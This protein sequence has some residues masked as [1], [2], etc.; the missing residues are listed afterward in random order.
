[1]RLRRVLCALT[2]AF[3]ACVLVLPIAASAADAPGLSV[4]DID[5]SAFPKVTFRVSVPPALGGDG[6][7]PSFTLSENGSKVRGATAE[8]LTGEATPA[9]VVLVID[10]SGSM[11]GKPL[12]DA[13]AAATRFLETLG[14]NASVAIVTFADKPVVVQPLTSDRG[15][16]TGSLG[17]LAAHGETALW[18]ALVTA[19]A[20]VPADAAGQRGIVVLSDGG[21]TVSSASF[22]LAVSRVRAAGAPVYAVALTSGEANPAALGRL[23]MSSGGRLVPVAK[24]GELSAS[25]E[26]IAREIRN[27]YLVTYTSKQPR[28]K[29]VEVDLEA[30]VGDRTASAAFAFSNPA[31]A[32][33]GLAATSDVFVPGVGT[34]AQRLL[35]AVLLGFGAVALLVGGVLSFVIRDRTT[36]DQ[37]RY[38]DQLH[39]AGSVDAGSTADQVRRSVVDAVGEVAGRRGLTPLVMAKLESAGMPLRPAEYMTL[40][41][42]LVVVAG[43]AAELVTG[44][45]IVGLLATIGMT[46]LPIVLLE[47]AIGRRRRKFEEQLPDILSMIAG[48]LRG[49]WGVQQAIGLV[50]QEAPAPSATEFRRVDTETRLGI[51]LEA[52]LQS[53]ASRMGSGDFQAAV[54]AI[55]I[56]REVGGN[57][58]EVLDVVSKTIRE[59]ES[60]RRHIK[61]LTA[62]GRLSAYILTALPFVVLGAMSV[63]NPGYIDLLFTNV[64]GIA[65]TLIGGVLLVVGIFWMYRVTKIEV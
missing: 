16:L 12:D 32:H 41:I 14:G 5:T 47:N 30:K 31:L 55:A 49:G 39:G 53:M 21:D 64:L 34:D 7:R 11:K 1:M 50:V 40:H 42:L 8:P 23:A 13:R 37:L 19:A 27:A 10:T 44:R 59:R 61:S 51:P 36:L 63:I 22:D 54:T 35:Y 4:Q 20:L 33:S 28:S 29:D 2:L 56:Q 62:E 15:A 18:D 43:V 24:S 9:R 52:S 46:V 6:A 38:Y 3:L 26:S 48:S 60:L 17:G 57:L 58:A 45:V 65:I 25:F